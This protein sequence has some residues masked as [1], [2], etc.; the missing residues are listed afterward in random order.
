MRFQ[1]T[2][3]NMA[4]MMSVL[5]HVACSISGLNGRYIDITR[6]K[7]RSIFGF[8]RLSAEKKDVGIELL[9]SEVIKFCE[10]AQDD[11]LKKYANFTVEMYEEISAKY[12]TAMGV[13]ADCIDNHYKKMGFAEVVS[14][15]ENDEIIVRY[16]EFDSAFTVISVLKDMGDGT[17]TLSI[18]SI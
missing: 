11:L 17:F 4:E 1:E 16:R 9:E 12:R 18:P 5:T 8:I 3:T 7:K 15:K 13:L 10:A 2:H 6:G 14:F